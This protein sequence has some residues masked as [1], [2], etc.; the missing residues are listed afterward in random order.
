MVETRAFPD[1]AETEDLRSS[2]DSGASGLD[3][4]QCLFLR[5]MNAT[6]R[7]DVWQGLGFDFESAMDVQADPYQNWSPV[8]QVRI[9][10]FNAALVSNLFPPPYK[11]FINIC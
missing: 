2:G 7:D 10:D 5:T 1:P 8:P 11:H 6:L 3:K 4:N 9:P